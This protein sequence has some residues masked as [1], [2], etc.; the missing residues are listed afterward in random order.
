M[1]SIQSNIA[2]LSVQRNLSKSSAAALS[3]STA[4][5]SGRRVSTAKDDAAGLGIA[6][7]MSATIATNHM[8]VRGV[9]DGISIVQTAEGALGGISE[10]LGRCTELAAQAANGALSDSDRAFANTEFHQLLAEVDRTSSSTTVFGKSPLHAPEIVPAVA[11][12]LAARG[13]ASSFPALFGVD[14]SD[15]AGGNRLWMQPPGARVVGYI[16]TGLTNV[17]FGMN[18]AWGDVDLQLFATD[19]T[20]ILGTPFS[21]PTWTSTSVTTPSAANALL[22]TTAN[23]FDAGASYQGPPLIQVNPAPSAVYNNNPLSPA[24]TA[25]FRGMQFSYTGDGDRFA[26]DTNPSAGATDW[27]HGV[28]GIVVDNVT[29]PLLAVVSA[30]GYYAYGANWS[31]SSASST[32]P[33]GKMPVDIVV[34]AGVNQSVDTIRIDNTPA[35]TNSLGLGTADLGSASGARSALDSLSAAMHTVSQHRATYGALANRFEV[36]ISNLGEETLNV[37]SARGRI[38]DTDIAHTVFERT[39][40]Q[41]LQDAGVSML[42]QSSRGANVALSLL[43]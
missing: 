32:K 8:L 34:G 4:L 42:A 30:R 12:T 3:A 22:L 25:S 38:V 19:G 17:N 31:S 33:G 27:D 14:G 28:E 10:I 2:A 37:E 21:D 6:T 9:N 16:P 15:A 43:R 18:S 5:S 23:G 29:E 39:R 7:R 26:D 11:P 24:T 35:D 40:A 13:A 1:V 20:H 41:V 36:A